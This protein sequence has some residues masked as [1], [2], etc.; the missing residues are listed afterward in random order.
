MIT[1]WIKKE[2]DAKDIPGL[3]AKSMAQNL[4]PKIN[5]LIMQSKFK[6]VPNR[7]DDRGGFFVVFPASS[8]KHWWQV[9]K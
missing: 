8:G 1:I 6:V 7:T 4:P 2:R 9:W 3:L 5:E